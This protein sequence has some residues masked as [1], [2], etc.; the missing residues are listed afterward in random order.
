MRPRPKRLDPNTVVLLKQIGIGV[1]VISVVVLALTGIWYG[2]R[3]SSLTITEVVASGGE[4][5][6]HVAVEELAQGVLDGM[7]VGFIP[8]RFAWW[9]PEREVYEKV[10][11]IE[12]IHTVVLSREGGTQLRI[13]YD[14]YIP[15]ALWCS[16]DEQCVFIN[17]AGY[18]F[19][20]APKLSGGSFLRF[21]TTG[22]EAKVGEVSLE[23]DILVTSR[24]VVELLAKQNWFV[25]HVEV[26]QVGDVFLKVVGGGE[27]KVNVKEPAEQTVEN[28]FVILT[29]DQ[30]KHLG[31]GKFQYIDLRFGEKVFVNEELLVVEDK[32]A[33]STVA[34]TSEA[35]VE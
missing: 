11:A 2:T 26:D 29:S 5:I 10:S 32:V 20:H 21:I 7:Y 1:V 24:T 16:D 28:L 19:A 35:T 13:T 33:S 8:R 18:A 31:P 30:F 12:R 15:Y 6:D 27:L 34:T 3:I 22:R 17:D 9:Y 4:T 25:S 14:E 23:E